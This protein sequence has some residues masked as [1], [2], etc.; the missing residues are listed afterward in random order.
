M[1][2]IISLFS[3]LALVACSAPKT[4]HLSGQLKDM[5]R[6]KVIMRYNGAASLL[7]DSRDIILYTDSEGRFDT[8]LPLEK[9]EYYSI[10]RNT[11]WLTPGDDLKVMI[12][13]DN[14]EAE[15]QGKGAAANTYMK[16]RLFPKGGAFLEGGTHVRESFSQTVALVRELAGKRERQLEELK[17]VSAEFKALEKARIYADVINSYLSYASYSNEFT[18]KNPE[19][20]RA[21][22]QLY[23]KEVLPEMKEKMAYLNDE[24]FLDVAVVRDILFYREEPGYAPIFEGYTPGERCRELYEGYGKVSA[25]RHALNQGIVDDNRVYIKSM[26]QVDFAKELTAKVNQAARLLPGQPAPDF[27]M[28]DTAGRVKKLSDF[29]GKVIY[30]DLWA[31]WCGPCIQESPAFTALS[32]RY[33]DVQFLQI[34]RDEQRN[35]WLSYVSHKDSPLVQY[36]SVDLQLVEG[37]QLYYIP[38]FILIDAEQKII[39]AYAPRPSSDEIRMV[40]DRCLK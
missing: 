4:V 14:R 32:A 8:I 3:V 30:I 9:P 29:R 33:P 15:F 13:Q 40:L 16:E 5:G 10:S 23:L 38:R 19:E 12:T 31:T 37:W 21:T 17:G 26:K 18:G 36:N 22:E 20:I 39:D 24:R 6:Q 25:L 35:A 11:L 2:K 28:T 27:V 7:G 1:Y 34:S